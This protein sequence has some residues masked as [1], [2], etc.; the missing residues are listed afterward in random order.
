MGWLKLKQQKTIDQFIVESSSNAAFHKEPLKSSI[1][2]VEIVEAPQST[3]L[4][5]PFASCETPD[6][7]LPH[8]Q[9]S[10]VESKYN[11]L[12][13]TGLLWIVIDRIVYDCT[14][15]IHHHPGGETVIKSFTGSDCSWQFWRFHS[16]N[17][18]EQ[19]GKELRIGRTGKVDNRFREPPMFVGLRR[20]NDD[21]DDW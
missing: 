20:L 21:S 1:E 9:S 11:D 18:L 2:H 10:E 19:Y 12:D 5:W 7:M 16:K 8:I 17:H 4:R 3:S 14:A 15:F 13:G 6:N